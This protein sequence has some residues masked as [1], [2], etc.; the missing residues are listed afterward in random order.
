MDDR[1]MKAVL[2][3]RYGGPGVLYVGRVPRPEPG[4]GEILVKVHAFSVNGGELAA[5]SGRLRL[6]LGRRFPKRVGLDFTGEVAALGTGVARFTPGDRVW[7]VLGRSS[8]FGS[9]AEY[10]TVPADRAGLLPD[11]LDPV[12]AAALPVATTAVTALRDKAGLRPGERLLV[13]GAAGGVGNVAV[14]LGRAYGAEVTALARAANLDL[15]RGL[16]AHEAVDHRSVRPADLGRFDV[17][18]DTAGTELRAHRALLN[19][20]GRMVTIAFDPGRPVTSLGYIAVSALHG[21]GRVRFFS[22]DP[23]QADFD[24]LARHVAEGALRPVVDRVFPLEETAAA[25][26]ALEAG[27]VRGKYVVRVAAE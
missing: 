5:R 19:P 13:R 7:G 15:V 6:L 3:D 4:P 10:V 24:V 23:R 20:G 17:V 27:G 8:G 22:G 25:H 9:A 26:R 12:E 1:T 14:Q 11:G 18:L 2:Y 21:R 16:G